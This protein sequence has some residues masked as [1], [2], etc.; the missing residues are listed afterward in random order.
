MAG[1]F[2][3]K[4][5]YE[6][7][8]DTLIDNLE[9]PREDILQHYGVKGMKWGVRRTDSQL[10]EASKSKAASPSRKSKSSYLEKAEKLRDETLGP[11]EITRTTKNGETVTLSKTLP[12]R[13]A[14]FTTGRSDKIR[15]GY[16]NAASF[17]IKDSSGKKVGDALV[18]KE[19]DTLELGWIGIK[20][21]S[22]GKG[23]A[24]AVL[25]AA[26]EFGRAEGFN[27]MTLEA[28]PREDA[29]HIYTSLGFTPTEAGPAGL[30]G[31]EYV[32][33]VKHMS[34]SDL[35]LFHYG[36]KGM[37]WGVRKNGN[38]SRKGIRQKI[39]DRDES[40]QKS[41]D[42][43][44][45]AII[46]EASAVN[47]SVRAKG[48]RVRNLRDPEAKAASKSATASR[49]EATA[50]R[51]EVNRSANR[52]TSKELATKGATV[53]IPIVLSVGYLTA[54]TVGTRR[55]AKVGEKIK[56]DLFAD[57]RGLPSPGTI[58]LKLVDGVW[59]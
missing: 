59:Q 35:E 46:R 3:L 36:V 30:L 22:R 41:R 51:K 56:T 10:G 19:G 55:N 16:T 50:N 58:A 54:G 27:K 39:K 33:D 6:P 38:S 4:E 12:G 14:V 34:S 7:L 13:L 44:A 47:R 37:K 48:N 32:F 28:V 25:S 20:P 43:Q 23:Y 21:G 8:L 11:R 2:N 1:D 53:A 17:E 31:M 26:E 57:T 5:E 9:N 15:E 24:T 49:K 52:M 29:R 18:G 45:D 42:Q 40:I